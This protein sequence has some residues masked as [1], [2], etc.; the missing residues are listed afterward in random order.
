M[1]MKDP[2]IIEVRGSRIIPFRFHFIVETF[3]SAILAQTNVF[4]PRDVDETVSLWKKLESKNIR[5]HQVQCAFIQRWGWE[6]GW[7]GEFGWKSPRRGIFS[8]GTGK[9]SE[10]EIG[11][12]GNL[13]LVKWKYAGACHLSGT[14]NSK[15]HLKASEKKG[16]V[17]WR[18]DNFHS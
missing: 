4:Q 17:V 3:S 14:E 13:V 8:Q 9:K 2:L 11:P 1:P 16:I 6:N 7:V 12:R 15:Y 18:N 10:R 5:Q